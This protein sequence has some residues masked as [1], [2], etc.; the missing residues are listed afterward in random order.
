MNELVRNDPLLSRL[1]RESAE[2]LGV[3]PEEIDNMCL[4]DL[5]RRL[6]LNRYE[7]ACAYATN[8]H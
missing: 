6:G 4:S 5:E 2:A 3:A 7:P 1:R 8:G